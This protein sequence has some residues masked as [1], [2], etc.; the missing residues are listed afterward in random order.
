M[1]ARGHQYR[2]TVTWTGNL[3]TG[4]SGYRDYSRAHLVEADGP[5]P[6]L[7]SSDPAFRGDA[8]RWNP[9]QL[10]VAALSQCH[11][12]QY[13]HLCADHGVV[14]TRYHD[15]ASGTLVEND[16]GSG[17]FDEVTLRPQVVVAESSM[18]ATALELHRQAHRLCF[19]AA[20]VS[21]PVHNDPTVTAL[22]GSGS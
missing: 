1:T 2:A 14:V 18:R 8:S 12:L 21:F 19:L 22:D 17:R 3:G 5:P 7:G 4:T 13:L 16:D 11:L 15:E 6:L 20:S 10:F 9:E